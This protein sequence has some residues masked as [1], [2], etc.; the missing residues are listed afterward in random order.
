MQLHWDLCIT[1]SFCVTFLSSLTPVYSVGSTQYCLTS[2]KIDMKVI[3]SSKV[4]DSPMVLRRSK[5][6]D[7]SLIEIPVLHSK[8]SSVSAEK[9][10]YVIILIEVLK[11]VE[12][13]NTLMQDN[14]SI[15][16]KWAIRTIT[17]T[18]QECHLLNKRPSIIVPV[19]P[20]YR[21]AIIKHS[22]KD[23]DEIH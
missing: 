15:G 17:R 9:W 7:L 11:A 23:V 10:S 18:R 21:Q 3:F 5:I 13:S 20:F 2:D 16:K 1:N 4:S 14:T 12:L 22:K 6:L 8:L 19:V